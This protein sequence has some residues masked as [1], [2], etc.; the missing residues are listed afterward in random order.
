MDRYQITFQTW[1]KVAQK[2]QDVFMD[3]DLYNETYD[4]FCNLVAMPNA[5]IF[6]IGCGPGN[7]TRYLL[8]K[9]PDFKIEAIDV[10]P[11]MIELAQKNNPQAHFKV[12]D[13]REIS[14]VTK[15]FD[16]VVCG[17]ILPYLSRED[18]AK[19]I[20]DCAALLN[21]GGIL[22]FSAI[23][24]PYEKSGFE[25]GS[26][27]ENKLYVYYHPE[28]YL[29]ELLQANGFE[30]VRLNRIHYPKGDLVDTHLVFMAWKS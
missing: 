12:M 22:Y 15:T 14:S 23:E 21:P 25:T 8:A 28:K 16:G 30:L 18:T 19:L 11:N 4:A 3:L 13:A 7:I 26:D 24:G 2:Y 6:E 10:S 29:L 1:D 17:F 5:S 20:K 9:R 27:L